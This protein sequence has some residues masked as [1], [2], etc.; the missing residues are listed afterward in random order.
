MTRRTLNLTLTYEQWGL[1]KELLNRQSRVYAAKLGDTASDA[2]EHFHGLYAYRVAVNN[3]SNEI[4]NELD[5]KIE[6]RR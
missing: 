1:I 3:L 2:P 4:A 6:R 5:C